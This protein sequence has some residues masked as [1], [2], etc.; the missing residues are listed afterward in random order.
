MMDRKKFIRTCCYSVVG[1]PL[2]I[3][4]LQGCTGGIHYAKASFENGVISLSKS[5][6]QT[7]ISKEE[8]SRKYIKGVEKGPTRAQKGAKGA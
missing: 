8:K 3:S 7:G 4:T 2:S 6:F 5:E 1:A